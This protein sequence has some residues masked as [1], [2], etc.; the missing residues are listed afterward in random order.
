MKTTL[1]VGAGASAPFGFPLGSELKTIVTQY[2]RERSIRNRLEQLNYPASHLDEL[3]ECLRYGR[4][5]T[6][7]EFLDA[8]KRFREIGGYIIAEAILNQE[9]HDRVFPARDWMA[10]LFT[11]LYNKIVS[12][13]KLD[14]TIVTL[15]YDRTIEYF[16]SKVTKYDCR[17][18][19]EDTVSDALSKIR[20]L[21]PHGSVGTLQELPFGMIRGPREAHVVRDAG[22]RIQIISDKLEDSEAFLTARGVLASSDRILFIGFAYHPSTMSAL[23]KDV[24][25]S[26]TELIGT[27]YG[28]SAERINAVKEWS[29]SKIQL[30]PT[31]AEEFIAH[32]VL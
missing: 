30:R 9:N 13:E 15:N 21:H 16:F 11:K 25:L 28:L 2:A 5:Q 26:R 29:G 27:S 3:D 12:T 18:D 20:V 17:E 19:E 31:V 6:I 32:N 14:L 24:N 1:V 22:R 8:K 23:F 7:D 10:T 4:Y